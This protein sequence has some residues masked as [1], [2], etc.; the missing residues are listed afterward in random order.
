IKAGR[1]SDALA[2]AM[3]LVRENPQDSNL[4]VLLFQLLSACGDW[5]RASKQLVVVSELS[6]RTSTLPIIY[7]RLIRLEVYRAAVFRGEKA[8]T[9]FGEPDPWISLMIQS[10]AHLTKGESEAALSLN[11]E[12]LSQAPATRGRVNGHS[13]D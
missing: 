13:F 11:Q 6:G 9:L 10:L 1:L 7:N 5:E 8:P 4:R 3:N 2:A 12:A